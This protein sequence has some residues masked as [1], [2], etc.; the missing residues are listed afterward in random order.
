VTYRSIPA[1]LRSG[2]GQLKEWWRPLLTAATLCLV[3]VLVGPNDQIDRRLSDRLLASQKTQADPKILIVEINGEDIRRYGGPPFSRDGL[4]KLFDRIGEARPERVLL[5]TY[6]GE[7]FDP[8]IDQRLAQSF[9]RLGPERLGLVTSPGPNDR[10]IAL[11]AQHATIVDARLTAD[12]DGWHRRIGDGKRPW[13][14]N[15]AGW[16]ATGSTSADPVKLDLRVATVGYERYS[17]HEVISGQVPLDGRLVVVGVSTKVAPSRAFL[18]FTASADR[19]AVLALGAQSIRSGYPA[20]SKTGGLISIALGV[21]AVALAFVCALFLRSGKGLTIMSGG[22]L[23]V[24]IVA[25]VAVARIYAV[26]I[27]PASMLAC[28]AVMVN[29]TL[30]QR[31][32]LVPMLTSFLKGD[33]SP[34]EAWAWR[35]CE[36]ASHPAVLLSA[37]G[38]VKRANREGASLASMLGDDLAS[39]LVPR[40]GEQS[41]T[42]TITEADESERVYEIDWPYSNVAIAVLRDHTEATMLDRT[43]RQQLLTDELTGRLNR[44]GFEFALNRAAQSE[45]GYAVFFLDMNGFKAVNDTHG[46]DAGDELLVRSAQRLAKQLRPEDS[47]A[48]LGGDEFAIV[49]PRALSELEAEHLAHRLARVI[50]QQVRIDCANAM[51]RVSAAIGHAQPRH[52][53]ESTAQVLRRADQAMYRNKTKSKQLRE[54]A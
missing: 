54:A 36:Q 28:F 5:D 25:S 51:V 30:I 11:F 27:A 40:V 13:G 39:L 45:A 37:N 50:E 32:K 14:V 42:I 12:Q 15:A 10:P 31:L 3:I 7:R 16:L 2:L 9:A 22:I 34:E 53:F 4:T 18:P 49:V 24:L 6:L 8:A 20:L 44:R 38:R 35:S 26:A 43:L 29:V 46:H 1:L 47:L 17:A 21:L 23:A 19:A 41:S 48:R 52:G 33:I